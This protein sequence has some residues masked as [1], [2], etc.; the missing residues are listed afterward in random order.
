[1]SEL[2][3][4]GIAGTGCYVPERVVDNAFFEDFLDTNDEWIRQ[5]TGIAERRYAADGEENSDMCLRAARQALEN[6]GMDAAELDL[7]LVATVSGDYQMPA[8]ACLVQK[9]LEAKKAGAFD[10]QAACSGFVTALGVGDAYIAAG[11]AE[12]V[13]VIGAEALSR[14]IDFEDRGSAILFGDGAG[15]AVLMPHGDCGQG[16][17]LKTSLGADG[18]GWAHIWLPSGG[19]KHPPSQNTIDEREHFIRVNGREVYRFAVGADDSLEGV[20]ER[21]L[22]YA[23]AV[24]EERDW[25]GAFESALA[26]A[27]AAEPSSMHYHPVWY[28]TPS[29][30]TFDIG[31]F[32]TSLSSAF[33]TALSSASSSSSSGS[34]GGGSTGGGGGGGG[35]GG[36]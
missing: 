25:S 19:S 17:I 27:S 14:F 26:K 32:G 9:G 22:P 24:G 18:E 30:S 11:R 8:T 33:S 2:R 29:N 23:I 35:G 1:M 7:I 20:Y 16:E 6:A 28:D 36:W 31:S 12:K 3:R 10:V 5:R 4:V 21:Y 13:L 34:G 15:A